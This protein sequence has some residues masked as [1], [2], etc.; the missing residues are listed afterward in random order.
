M[1]YWSVGVSHIEVEHEAEPPAKSVQASAT[2]YCTMM[3][4]WRTRGD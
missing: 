2:E 4:D 1:A 3:R